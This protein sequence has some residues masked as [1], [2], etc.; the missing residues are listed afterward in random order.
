VISTGLFARVYSYE[1]HFDQRDPL[2][3]GLA[4]VFNLERGLILG[5]IIFLL[6]FLL[7]L[8]VLLRW[9]SVDFGSLSALRPAIV[10]GTLMATGAQVVFSSFFLS[11]LSVKVA[12]LKDDAQENAP[13]RR[14]S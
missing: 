12:E 11:M 7:D 8:S 1:R 13:E 6:G 9:V 5:A 10:G 3:R 14:V 2:L 4:R